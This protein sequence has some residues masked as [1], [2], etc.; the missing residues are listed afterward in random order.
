MTISEK[1]RISQYNII[2]IFIYNQYNIIINGLDTT[3]RVP[4]TLY[5]E[6]EPWAMPDVEFNTMLQGCMGKDDSTPNI[7]NAANN[8]LDGIKDTDIVCFTDGSAVEATRNGGAGGVINI[9]GQDKIIIKRAGGVLCSSYRAEMI[10]IEETLT[11][12]LQNIDEEVEFNRTLWIFTDSQSSITTLRQGAGNQFCQ[13]GNTIWRLINHICEKSLKIIFQ[14]IP[15]HKGIDGNEEADKAA[16]EASK[17]LQDQVP[18]NFETIKAFLKRR[19]R[20]DW[21]DSVKKQDLPTIL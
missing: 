5:P 2:K 6:L 1:L 11:N 13:T 7:Q 9:P 4:T 20:E 16:G 3:P 12:V 8:I 17:L 15:G 21:L 14:W 10:A 19:A 18:V